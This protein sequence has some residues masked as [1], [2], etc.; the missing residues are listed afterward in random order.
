MFSWNPCPLG[1][2]QEVFFLKP[3]LNT[4]TDLQSLF[5]P[6]ISDHNSKS[7][8]EM[9]RCHPYLASHLTCYPTSFQPLTSGAAQ[10]HLYGYELYNIKYQ[11]MWLVSFQAYP[12][13]Y[14]PNS[15]VSK[16]TW[17]LYWDVQQ[18]LSQKSNI[19]QAGLYC[20]LSHPI[21]RH[22]HPSHRVQ[23]KLVIPLKHKLACCH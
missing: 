7:A 1:P 22:P 15:L 3:S 19:L 21:A 17:S 16:S 9:L 8:S 18:T 13:S 20:G 14:T 23:R 11:Y 5:S 10:S 4:K 6:S 2:S 12:L